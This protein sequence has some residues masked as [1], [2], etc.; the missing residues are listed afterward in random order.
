V[1]VRLVPR[2]HTISTY[3]F[4]KNFNRTTT[5]MDV[6]SFG[7]CKYMPVNLSISLVFS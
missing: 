7:E 6:P 3:V 2:V 1:C 4:G 5:K